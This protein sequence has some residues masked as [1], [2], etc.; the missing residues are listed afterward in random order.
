MNEKHLAQIVTLTSKLL[1]ESDVHTKQNIVADKTIYAK[2]GL[3]VGDFNPA[4]DFF[5]KGRGCVTGDLII[6]GN[7]LYENSGNGLL[8]SFCD[9]AVLPN[10]PSGFRVRDDTFVKGLMWD[11]KDEEF[12]FA[13]EQYFDKRQNIF[14]QNVK[15]KNINFNNA[16]CKNILLESSIISLNDSNNIN[17]EGNLCIKGNTKIEGNL[18]S[19]GEILNIKSPLITK[20]IRIEGGLTVENGV[21]ITRELVCNGIKTNDMDCADISA[22]NLKVEANIDVG[23][24]LDISGYF[25]AKKGGEFKQGL[26]VGGNLYLGKSLIFTGDETG[27]AFTKLSHL[28]NASVSYINNKKVNTEGDIMTTH[29]SQEL[30]NKILG[31]YLDAKYFKIKNLDNPE[32]NYDAV[33]KKYVDQFVTGGHIL[34]PTRLATNEKLDAVFMA[35]AYQL[36]SKNMEQLIVDCVEAKIGDR[37]LVKN[38]Q[39]PAENGIYIV[40]S[41]GH[42]N[43]Q[44][45]LQLADD[46]AD[47]LKNR[48]RITPLILSRFGEKNGRKIFGLNFITQMVWEFMDQEDFVKKV[49]DP[50][51]KI[52]LENKELKRRIEALEVKNNMI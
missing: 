5:I 42:K 23:Q 45:I 10:K 11:F 37:I 39:N 13:D 8:N 17:V 48:P 32:D 1:E 35:S 9:V 14:L 28:E 4:Y 34:E 49:W 22:N 51:E 50:V 25:H 41:K 18:Y 6:K 27:I 43:Q 3:Y 47:I 38:Q 12:I 52:L 16:Y 33:N 29:G 15:L 7:L 24:N 44:W 30:H 40:I 19:S 26:E 2:D 46:C 20:T 21:E 31:T 36:V